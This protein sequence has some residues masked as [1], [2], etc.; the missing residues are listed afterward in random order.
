[1]R[2]LFIKP[3]LPCEGTEQCPYEYDRQNNRDVEGMP[4]AKGDSRSCPVYG[5]ICP[6]FMEDFGL[7]VNELHIRASIHCGSLLEYFV[8]IGEI[9][10]NSEEY[11]IQMEAYRKA[12]RQFPK[13]QFPKYY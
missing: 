10:R 9:D 8:Q 1:M 5:H 13:K 2:L 11:K 3:S 7:T 4:F 12:I 6:K